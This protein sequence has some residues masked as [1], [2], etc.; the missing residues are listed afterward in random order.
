MFVL[1][2]YNGMC[3]HFLS[4]ELHVFSGPEVSDQ[5]VHSH[6]AGPH[7]SLPCTGSSGKTRAH[8]YTSRQI[9][10][11]DLSTFRLQNTTEEFS[12]GCGLVNKKEQVYLDLLGLLLFSLQ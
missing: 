1:H 8:T 12:M 5:S 6:T 7:H 2:V 3:V 10:T 4:T 9:L 11:Q